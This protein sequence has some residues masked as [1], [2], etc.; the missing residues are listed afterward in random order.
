[1]PSPA[2]FPSVVESPVTRTRAVA[3]AALAGLVHAAAVVALDRTL[4]YPVGAFG[5]GP[6]EWAFFA[7][8]AVLVAAGPVYAALRYRLF[9][10]V[11]AWVLLAASSLLAAVS[12]PRPE[13]SELGGYTVVA[14]TLHL[15]NYV[16]G[17]YCWL[18]AFALAALVEY[19]VRR[20]VDWL[21]AS[22]LRLPSLDATDRP[23][24]LRAAAVAGGAHLLAVL[25]LAAESGYFAPGSSFARPLVLLWV[26]PG[27]VALAAVPA[28]LLARWRLI[29][30]LAAFAWF[31]F[32]VAEVQFLPLPD[33]GLPVYLLGWPAFVAAAAVLGA[34]ESLLRRAVRRFEERPYAA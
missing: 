32:R 4:A 26:L 6:V 27:A 24:A 14:G 30:P 17:W 11:A 28:F 13:F 21:P 7:A 3:L 16:Q 1:M 8:G 15:R 29:A 2:A 34:A 10:P 23:G 5:R 19:A 33:D 12:G 18:L 25:L 20:D 22:P 9:V 31:F